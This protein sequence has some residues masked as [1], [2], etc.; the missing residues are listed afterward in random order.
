MPMESMIFGSDADTKNQADLI[1]DK[2]REI[3]QQLEYLHFQGLIYDNPIR[4]LVMG[5]S[6]LSSSTPM[7]G[8]ES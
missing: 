4:V 7:L 3:Y 1:I 5:R 8:F 6:V 2:K